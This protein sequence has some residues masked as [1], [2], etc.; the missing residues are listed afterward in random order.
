L[1]I[2]NAYAIPVRDLEKCVAFYRDKVG[3][4]LKDRDVDFAYLVFSNQDKPGLAL[5]TM[6]NAANLISETQVRPNE[7][8]VHRSY[9][10]V[11]VDDV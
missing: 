5:M 1:T 7:D 3:L 10:A 8:A 11:F 2:S 6:A 4:I 9:F